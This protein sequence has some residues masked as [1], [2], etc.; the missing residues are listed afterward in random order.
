MSDVTVL[1]P[2]ALDP[3]PPGDPTFAGFQWFV[4]NSMNVPPANMPDPEWMQYCYDMAM[5][6]AYWGL[7]GVPSQP[8]SP[9][10]Y[11]MAVYNLGAHFLVEYTMDD[12]TVSPPSTYWADLRKSLGIGS[13]SP[14]LLTSASDQGTSEGMQIPPSILNGI[15]FGNLEM[16]KTPWGRAYLSI[17]GQWGSIWGLTI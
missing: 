9:S 13:F 6:L 2:R 5:N 7:Q 12:P 8:T 4:S 15:T 17:A 3:P 11:A 16:M 14:G 1:E 10:I